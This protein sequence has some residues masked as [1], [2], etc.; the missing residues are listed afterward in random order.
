MDTNVILEAHRTGAWRA[1]VGRYRVE[2]VTECVT[3]TQTGFQRRRPEQRIDEPALRR[4][5]AAVHDVTAMQ[6]AAAVLRDPLFSSLDPGERDLWAHALSRTDAW[7]LCGPDKASVRLGVRLG[8]RERLVT[9]EGLLEHAGHRPR[10]PLRDN[11]TRKWLA[12]F[13]NVLALESLPCP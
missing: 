2:T 13:L 10:P 8:F 9:L 6:R 11:Y 12:D 7:F 3:E 4:S 5:L 1:L